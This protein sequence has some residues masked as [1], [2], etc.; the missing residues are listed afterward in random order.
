[1]HNILFVR[2]INILFVYKNIIVG[3]TSINWLSLWK[4]PY[5]IS[6]RQAIEL[7][8]PLGTVRGVMSQNGNE[9]FKE[10]ANLV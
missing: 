9:L 7:A 5:K 10:G 2:S 4:Q 3:D 8:I 6:V 1:M